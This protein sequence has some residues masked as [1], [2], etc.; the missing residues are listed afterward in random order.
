MIDDSSSE[1]IYD[2]NYSSSRSKENISSNS[3]KIKSESLSKIKSSSSSSLNINSDKNK[4]SRN[5]NYESIFIVSESNEKNY[6]LHLKIK[7][8]IVKF[9]F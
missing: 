7:K 4:E 8:V 1:K 6:L 9:Y 3:I 2:S 5:K